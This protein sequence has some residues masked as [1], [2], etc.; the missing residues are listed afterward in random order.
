MRR[1]KSINNLANTLYKLKDLD[2]AR[3]LL[4][5]LVDIRRTALGPN[6]YLGTEVE[7]KSLSSL[8]D[9]Y[10]DLQ[11][12]DQA[13]QRYLQAFDALEAQT[14]T[15]AA[16]EDTRSSFKARWES[17]YCDTLKT[18]LVLGRKE[19]AHHVLERFRAQGVLGLL[20]ERDIVP[21]EMP[22]DLEQRRRDLDAEYDRTVFV[23]D[24]LDPNKQKEAFAAVIKR[25]QELRRERERL[26]AELRRRAPNVAELTDPQPLTVAQIRSIL[27]PGT[28]MLSYMVGPE[29]TYLFALSRDDEL[30]VHEIDVDERTFWQQTARFFEQ[31][32]QPTASKTQASTSMMATWLYGKLLGDVSEQIRKSER[33]LI[34]PDGPMFY[35]PFAALVGP[36][37]RY[38]GES[39]AIHSVVSATVYAQLQKRRRSEDAEGPL[40]IAAFGNP[41]YPKGK[42]ETNERIRT[43]ME[44]GLFDGGL[45]PLPS[46]GREVI[47][48]GELYPS[49]RTFL[50][51]DASEEN[52]KALAADIGIIHLATHGLA[53]PITPLDSFIA[54]SVTDDPQ[55]ENGLLQAWEIYER[56]RLDA[57]LVVL[58]A[59][60]T[61]FG[62]ERDGEGLIS[63]SRAFQVA[64]ART[65]VASL[66]SVNDESTAELMIRFYKHLKAGKNKDEALRAAQL[67]FIRGPVTFTDTSGKVVERDF[68]SPYYWA[69]FQ[70]IGDWQ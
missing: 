7:Y 59:C 18:L 50:G 67:E 8:A 61:A 60:Q 55:R 66:W 1:T 20:A 43:A 37:G 40:Q 63:L 30:V 46:S 41:S 25:Q 12:P 32:R 14:R 57:D 39:K 68:S 24:Q 56:L 19:E 53:D 3:S 26:N 45:L 34:L 16:A 33:L 5:E 6:Q 29:K 65:V 42:V 52:V 48:I 69:P 31:L 27:E 22:P 38:L 9:I 70:V 47:E 64:G 49:S 23:R 11:K 17:T 54:L 62:R 35:I 36:D 51:E 10:R 21:A 13:A 28:L 58:S 2:G 4:V 44:R 15:L